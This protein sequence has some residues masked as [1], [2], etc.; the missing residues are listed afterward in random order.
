VAIDTAAG[1]PFGVPVNTIKVDPVSSSALYGGTH[2]GVYRS[3]DGEASGSRFGSGM[4]LVNVEDLY[5]SPDATLVRAA[6]FGRG[7]WQLN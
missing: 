4:P 7:F 5:I 3:T 1:F 6:A 2:L